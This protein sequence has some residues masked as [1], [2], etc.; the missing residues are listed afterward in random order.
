MKNIL[1]FLFLTHA[2]LG[3]ATTFQVW[4]SRTYES[5]NAL[6]AADVVQAG[7]TIEIDAETYTGQAALAVW[8]AN[9]LLIKGVGGQAQLVASGEYIWGKGIWVCRGDN[10]TVEHIEF[11]GASVPDGNGAGI[12]LD[13]IGLTVRYCYFHDNENGILAGN[14]YAGDIL[15]EFS[16]FA[17][18]GYGDGY[19]HNLYIGHVNKLTFRYNYSH[20]AKV[21]H[22]L[23][24]RAN[25][26]Y[27]LYN[28]IMDEESGYSSRLID[29]SNGGFSIIMGNLLMQG[30][31]AENNNLVGYGLEGLSNTSAH[32][33]YFINNTLV[34][35]RQASC[36]F[37]DIKNGTS[38][39]NVSNNIFAGSGT[40]INGTTTTMDHNLIESN[41]AA[42]NFVDEENHDYQLQ[43]NAPAID[44]G[45]TVDDVNGYSLTP[46]FEYVHPL[47]SIPRSTV[48]DI[49]DAGAYEY[50]NI[51]ANNRIEP[52]PITIFPNP[53]NGVL[54]MEQGD[55]PVDEIMLYNEAGTILFLNSMSN[56]FDLSD[57]PSGIYYLKIT[58]KDTLPMVVRIVKI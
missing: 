7:D 25:E 20:H 15:I 3:A 23:K 57:Y 14:P 55:L 4:A 12:R 41:I 45:T 30:P 6:Y 11:S 38:I 19:T 39:A 56:T 24:S 26:N 43:A 48:N 32:E 31:E 22:N 49:I 53:T 37:V 42:L 34:N 5:P 2:F 28:R 17:N 33:L 8:S 46:E 40:I 21:G 54:Y 50:G 9:D 10:I 44:F 51:V 13:G 35:K 16:E 36:I 18:N 58:Y 27:I 29:L 1:L 47:A 52:T